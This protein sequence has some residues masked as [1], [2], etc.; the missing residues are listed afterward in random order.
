MSKTLQ[1][2]IRSAKMART[3]VVEVVEKKPH[4]LYRKLL[5]RSKRYK[6]DTAEFSV[7]VGDTVVIRKT[8]PLSKG[9]HFQIVEVVKP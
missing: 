1:G 5:K 2:T 6:V 8:R 3:A 4:P 7:S 9:K